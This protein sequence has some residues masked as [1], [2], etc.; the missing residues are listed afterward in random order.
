MK[1]I[2]IGIDG[3][4]NRSGGAKIHL[5]EII[6]NFQNIKKRI[7]E[8]HVWANEELLNQIPDYHWLHKHKPLK[9]NS[10]IIKE[11][12]W[13]YFIF[14]KKLKKIGIDILLNTSAVTLNRFKPNVTM[15]R[16]M[17][18][19][20]KGVIKNSG[21]SLGR[22]RL[23]LIKYIQVISLK[24]ADSVIFLTKYASKILQNFTGK[25]NDYRVI[26]HGISERFFI[27]N[28]KKIEKKNVL[29][30]IYVSN[31]DFYKHQTNVV[32]ALSK[33]KN[34]DIEL[35]LVGG[36]GNGYPAL[37][38]EKRLDKTMKQ[39]GNESSF[40]KILGHIDYNE[41]PKLYA[42]SDIIIF[43]SSC[44]N[45]PNT[46]VEGMATGLPIAS[47]EL[48][49]MKEILKDG[50]IYF[51]PYYEKSIYEAV[52]TLVDNSSLRLKL[53]SKS[54]NLSKKFSWKKCSINT[55]NYLV[56]TYDKSM[57]K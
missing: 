36:L 5:I 30:C 39:L 2:K 1:Q 26:N 7:Q 11:L 43:A 21:F 13:Q 34:N 53:S 27:D 32:K 45:M 17:L 8:V 56:E 12:Y 16:D 50:G 47:S 25:I 49:P 37:I 35:I 14:P 23:I 9:N 44:E 41:L 22:L 20:E 31:I 10:S 55:F 38:E 18:S 42:Q 24:R 52:K 46:L 6:K 19:F 29:R 3:S 57:T 33:F 51:N 48:G 54:Y 4:R 28:K 40:V 15:S